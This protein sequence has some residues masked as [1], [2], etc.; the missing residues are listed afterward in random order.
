[1][2]KIWIITE[3]FYPNETSTAFILTH[4]AN[5]LADSNEVNV[6]CGPV[7]YLKDLDSSSISLD[8]RVKV[9]R[10]SGTQLNKNNILTRVL[11]FVLLTIRLSFAILQRVNKEERVLVV[12]NPAPILLTV[13]WI[14]KIKKTELF[15]LVHDVFP[16]NTIPAGLFRSS[17]SLSFRMLKSIFNKAYSSADKLIV[18]GRDM[19]DVIKSKVGEG[20]DKDIIIIENWG[21]TDSVKPKQSE[22]SESSIRLQYAGNLGR[23]QGLMELLD[24]IRQADNPSLS[25]QFWG[26]GAMRKHMTEYVRNNNMS[27]VTFGGAYGRNQ[28]NSILTDCDLAIVT[29]ADGMYGLGVPSKTYNILA[30][31]KPILFIGDARS[32]IALLIKE[33][34]IGYVFEK[35]DTEALIKFFSSLTLARIHELNE[36]GKRARILAENSYSQEKIMAKY[37]ELFR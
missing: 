11:R 7:E 12:T 34:N 6:L 10:V 36:K 13:A 30:A 23:V 35:Q 16:E 17:E 21:E 27:K 9:H 29:L 2:K 25:Y 18:L 28:Q 26:D 20:R 14:K 22:L 4:I 37:I 1:M 15:L 33:N 5:A 32:E 8:P 3:L 24:C 31:G 19:K